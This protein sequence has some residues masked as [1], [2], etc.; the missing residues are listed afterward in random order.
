MVSLSVSVSRTHVMDA[1]IDDEEV[2]N[3]TSEASPDKEST[4]AETGLASRK[5]VLSPVSSVSSLRTANGTV[6]FTSVSSPTTSGIKHGVSSA[7]AVPQPGGAVSIVQLQIPNQSNVVQSVIQPNQQS[8][9]QATGGAT[10]VQTVQL[11]KNVIFV[12]KVGQG[13][14]IQSTDNTDANIHP[15]QVS[16]GCARL[17]AQTHALPSSATVSNFASICLHSQLISSARSDEPETVITAIEDESKKRR[18]V[19]ARRPSYRKILNELSSAETVGAI[20]SLPAGNEIKT[21]EPEPGE[22]QQHQQQRTDSGTATITVASPY[23]KVV[24]ASAIQLAAGSQDGT[25]QGIPTLTMTNATGAGTSAIVQYATQGQDGQ[26]FVPGSIGPR[27]L[28]TN[29]GNVVTVSAADLQAYQIRTGS[30]N[31]PGI[32]QGVVMTTPGSM[33]TQQHQIA[34]DAAKKREMRLLKNR[35]AA[36]ECRRKKKEYIKCLENRVAVLENQNK[37]L[38][39]ELKSL[40]ELYCQKA[41]E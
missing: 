41:V 3:A 36:K 16:N 28:C 4:A 40:K 1:L 11:P 21:E 18:E 20:S 8:V 15:V 7:I 38:I 29:G 2:V 34:E 10:T 26:F 17:R 14:V 25:L 32:A 24:P 30:G 22:H 39:E 37:A 27:L 9:I 23:L 33:G 31:A 5:S 19:L 35:E 13:S 6:V 12:N